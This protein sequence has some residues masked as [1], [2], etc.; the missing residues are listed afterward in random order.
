MKRAR[1]LGQALL[2]VMLGAAAMAQAA[3]AMSK[4]AMQAQ[5]KSITANYDAA[6]ARCKLRKGLDRDVCVA[7]AKGEREVAEAELAQ[8]YEPSV[9]N[10]EKLRLARADAAFEVAREK[11]EQYEGDAK[12]VCRKDAKAVQAAAH[13][14]A[15][16]QTPAAPSRVV[17]AAAPAVAVAPA[18]NPQLE[19]QFLAARER[20]EMMQGEARAA[21]L[22][23]ARQRF[24]KP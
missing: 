16:L 9:R 4:D 22:V 21:C 2:A 1:R 14:Q 11:C 15:K 19:A 5:K 13:A 3:P 23:S 17:P 10:D 18:A 20:C 12:D 7:A 24:G 8:R 6:E